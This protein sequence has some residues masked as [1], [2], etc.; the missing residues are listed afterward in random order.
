[1][2]IDSLV[3]I[4]LGIAIWM[5]FFG[6]IRAQVIQSDPSAVFWIIYLFTIWLYLGVVKRS[7]FGTIGYRLSQSNWFPQKVVA[8]VI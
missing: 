4:L 6:L 5:P 7:D 1:M 8:F 3:L 2:A